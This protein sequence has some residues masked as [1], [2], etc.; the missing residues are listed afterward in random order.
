MNAGFQ[1]TG[2]N[3]GDQR[4]GW[5]ALC[6]NR[7][8]THNTT[9]SQGHVFQDD[10]IGADPAPVSDHYFARVHRSFRHP[11]T[12]AERVIGIRDENTGT[13][14][15]VIADFNTA[16]GVDN[17]VPVEIVVVAYPD[18]DSVVRI[19][20]RPQPA[21]TGK[22]V[23]RAELNL[24]WPPDANGFQPTPG[25]HLH[26]EGPIEENPEAAGEAHCLTKQ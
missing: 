14:H 19:V 16:T 22:R 18:P 1:Q 8:G 23:H 9:V 24:S 3:A 12:G 26:A 7:A 13:E 10:C 4:T 2:R 21:T 5:K 6:D 17:R 15:V 20:R 11:P 25:A